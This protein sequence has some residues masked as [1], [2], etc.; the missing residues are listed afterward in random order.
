MADYYPLIARAV[1]GLERNTGDARRTLYERARTA[2]VAQLRGVT[3]ALSE[4]DVTRERLALEEAIRKVEAESARQTLAEPAHKEPSHRVRAPEMPRWDPPSPLAPERQSSPPP[5]LPQR[6]DSLAR[7]PAPAPRQSPGLMANPMLGEERYVDPVFDQPIAG[8]QTAKAKQ[9]AQPA[10]QPPP[11]QRHPLRARAERPASERPASERPASERTAGDRRSLLDSG[12]AGLRNAIS[13]TDE[14]GGASSR[15]AKSARDNYAGIAPLPRDF[16]H[17]AL[18]MPDPRSQD[19]MLQDG[20]TPRMLEPAIDDETQPIPS[21]LRMPPLPV[22]EE[23][24]EKRKRS[25]RDYAKIL[26]VLLL[27]AGLGGSLV[28][29]WPTIS[30]I[31]AS[32]RTSAP[33]EVASEPTVSPPARK[34]PE[35]FEPAGAPQTAQ[36]QPAAVTQSGAAVAQ[37]VVLYEEDPDDPQGKRFVGS[38]IWRTESVSPGPGMPPEVAVRADVEIPERRIAMTWSL[39]RNSDPNLPASHTVEIMF[40]LPQ[41]FP[42]GG[43]SNVP[44]ILMKQAEQSRGTPLSGL[45]VKVTTG[46][47]LIGLSSV[48]ADRERNVQLLKDRAWFDIPV[49]YSNNRRAILALEKGTPGERAFVE[50]FQAWKQ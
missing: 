19:D 42:S 2:L 35:R 17:R 44:G 45:A 24:A 27:L 1:A 47:F 32:L 3:P 22:Q 14:L 15:A 30:Q 7:K 13:E 25:F 28:V 20:P 4:S 37:R 41:D 10:P 38:A 49:V 6:G 34:N 23:L 5:P 43:V 18:E 26:V 33:I 48:E 11:P 40:R 39:R 12:L 16:D 29:L 31:Y 9:P 36:P 46:F 21:R 50:A 8:A